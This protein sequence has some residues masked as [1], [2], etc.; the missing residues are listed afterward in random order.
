MKH[1]DGVSSVATPTRT[2]DAS[3]RPACLP[4]GEG[5]RDRDSKSDGGDSDGDLPGMKARRVRRM[6]KQN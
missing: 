6:F 1:G 5:S 2:Q 3:T 4:V